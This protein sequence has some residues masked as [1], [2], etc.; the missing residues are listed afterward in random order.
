MLTTDFHAV[1]VFATLDTPV[2][3]F[4]LYTTLFLLAI[5]L[6]DLHKQLPSPYILL[7]CLKSQFNF[8]GYSE[9]LIEDFIIKNDICLVNDKSY[10]YINPATEKLSS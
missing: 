2:L 1:A 8:W 9:A 5:Y 4:C 10:R 7:V 3:R 6:E